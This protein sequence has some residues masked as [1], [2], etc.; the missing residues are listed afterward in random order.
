[1]EFGATIETEAELRALYREPG[2]IVKGKIADHLNEAAQGFIAHAPFLLLATADGQGRTDVS[3]RGGPPGFVRVLDRN[4]LVIPDLNGNNLLDSLSN[5]VENG[6]A[7]LLFVH[8]GRDETLRVEGRACL[9][10]DPEFLALWDGELRPPKVAVGVEVATAYI[11][12]AK[13]FRRGRVWDP[14]MWAE[15]EASGAPDTCDILVETV[16]LEI[17]AE[18]LR[19]LR[20]DGYAEQLAHDLPG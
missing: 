17:S 2:A 7:G 3:P 8:P 6:H 18:Q 16:P 10:T 14:A 20:E 19:D 13:S 1:M 12:C 15:I 5:I 4:R 11:H 9:T